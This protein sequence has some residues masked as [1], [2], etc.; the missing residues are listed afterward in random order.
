MHM[1]GLNLNPNEQA[2]WSA[3]GISRSRELRGRLLELYE[4]LARS[5]AARLYAV[6]VND[7]LPFDDYLQYARVGLIEAVDRFELSRGVAFGAYSAARIRGAILNGL[8]KSTEAA[9]QTQFFR[10]RM[11]D[12]LESLTHEIA[13]RIEQSSLE[14]IAAITM[15][16]AAG[17]LLEELGGSDELVDQNPSNNPY[18]ASEIQQLSATVRRLI[19]LLPA[20]EKTVIEGHYLR[21]LE[22]QQ[23]AARLAISKGRVSQLHAQALLRLRRALEPKAKLDGKF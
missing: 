23:L 12:R 15:G 14:D 1:P 4:P 8:A 10:A 18:E 13:P 16:L 17:M 19:V 21:H 3:F 9:A 2:L 11:R 22:F 20:T 6:R 5:M 7:S